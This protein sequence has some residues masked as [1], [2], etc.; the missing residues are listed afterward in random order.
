[1]VSR[2][3]QTIQINRLVSQSELVGGK[4]EVNQLMHEKMNAVF[5][6]AISPVR[7]GRDLSV[8]R[9][10][11]SEQRD[12]T[13]NGTRDPIDRMWHHRHTFYIVPWIVGSL[14]IGTLAVDDFDCNQRHNG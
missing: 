6:R 13:V 1:M 5:R 4:V 12:L 8:K 3:V 7:T 11:A 14:T 10:M 9:F 2:G